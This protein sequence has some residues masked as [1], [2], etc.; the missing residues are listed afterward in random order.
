[1]S[2]NDSTPADKPA[3]PNPDFPL[4]AHAAVWAKKIRG[5]LHYFGKWDDPA[6]RWPSTT[7]RKTSCTPAANRARSQEGVWVKLVANAFLTH[8][9]AP[10]R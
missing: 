1:M 4:S 3:K 6:V 8:K 2:N 5:K 10:V 7:H 9:K